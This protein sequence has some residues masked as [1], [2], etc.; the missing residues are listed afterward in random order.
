[1]RDTEIEVE[2]ASAGQR[3]GAYIINNVYMACLNDGYGLCM[4][5][6]GIQAHRS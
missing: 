1:M 6:V 5:C 2:L 4:V 3:I